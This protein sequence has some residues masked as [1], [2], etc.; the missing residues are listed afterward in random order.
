[1]RPLGRGCRGRANDRGDSR[2]AGEGAPRSR[3]RPPTLADAGGR[4]SRADVSRGRGGRGHATSARSGP[5][6]EPAVHALAG[7]AVATGKAL[8]AER[9]GD[10]SRDG[11]RPAG[12][13]TLLAPPLLR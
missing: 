7:V 8:P 3:T 10:S 2:G 11:N 5:G 1:Q 6:P 4:R 12:A 13:V 9:A